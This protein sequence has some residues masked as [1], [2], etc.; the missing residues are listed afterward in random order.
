MIIVLDASI[1][2]APA[3]VASC[4]EPALSFFN[5][6]PTTFRQMWQLTNSAH[7]QNGSLVFSTEVGYGTEDDPRKRLLSQFKQQ[8]ST[9]IDRRIRFLKQQKQN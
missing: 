3:L 5:A 9:A 2:A 7:Q 6:Y 1:F 8:T 4:E